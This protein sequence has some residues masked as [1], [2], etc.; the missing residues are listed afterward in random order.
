MQLTQDKGE[1]EETEIETELKADKPKLVKVIA[2]K[3]KKTPLKRKPKAIAPEPQKKAKVTKAPVTRAKTKTIEESAK[4]VPT[5]PKAVSIGKDTSVKPKKRPRRKLKLQE[6]TN[7][8][9]TESD[10][11]AKQVVKKKKEVKSTIE[12]MCDNIRHNTDM[13]GFKK[14]IYTQVTN[15]DKVLLEE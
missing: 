1:D 3:K 14:M 12:I 6:S 10:E 8:D 5:Q 15:D 2:K 4:A 11:A 7:E 9:K 13:F